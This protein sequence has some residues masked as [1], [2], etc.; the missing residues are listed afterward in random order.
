VGVKT[1]VIGGKVS[2]MCHGTLIGHDGSK[3]E[4]HDGYVP[5]VGCLDDG[6][7]YLYFEIDNETGVIKNWNPIETFRT[8]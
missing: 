4:E 5:Q 7:D 8:K 3:I 6:A 2:D 1:V